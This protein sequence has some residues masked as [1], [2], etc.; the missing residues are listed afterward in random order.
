[1]TTHEVLRHVMFEFVHVAADGKE[2]VC[3]TL[4]LTNAT[5]ASVRQLP[6]GGYKGPRE[7]VTF[8]FEQL[9]A[10]G[11]TASPSPSSIGW[12]FGNRVEALK[13]LLQ[14]CTFVGC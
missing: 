8:V 3:K 1:M 4:R 9:E 5:V 13:Y 6:S 12:A 11:Q 14:C 10:T 7:E 2:E